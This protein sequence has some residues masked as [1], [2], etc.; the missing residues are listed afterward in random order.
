M[1]TD[2]YAG[3]DL[4]AFETLYIKKLNSEDVVE[5]ANHKDPNAKSQTVSIKPKQ[6]LPSTGT[7]AGTAF[8]VVGLGALIGA[9]V[10]VLRAKKTT[11]LE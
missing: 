9:L 2:E 7:V 3:E 4:V 11:Q 8:A 5:V 6:P 1:N 10:L